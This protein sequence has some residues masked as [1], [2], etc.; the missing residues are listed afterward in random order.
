MVQVGDNSTTCTVNV[1]GGT[2]LTYV[3]I[4]SN[5]SPSS[6]VSAYS[7]SSANITAAQRSW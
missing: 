5:L 3:Q 2:N 7:T 6:Q 1:V 4:G